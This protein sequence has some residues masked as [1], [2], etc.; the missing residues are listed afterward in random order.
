MRFGFVSVSSPLACLGIIVL[1]ICSFKL[2]YG[3][4]YELIS[5]WGSFGL[6]NGLFDQP[7]QVGVSSSDDTFYVID[8][9]N[10]RIQKFATDGPFIS[11]WGIGGPQ[12]GQ[13]NLPQGIAVDPSGMI[14][15]VADT[16]NNRIQ[17]FDSNGNFV[18][19]WGKIGSADGQLKRPSSITVDG[20]TKEVFVVDSLNNRIQK[21]DSNGNFVTKW[22]TTGSGNGQFRNPFGIAIDS[23]NK[24]Y[25]SDRKNNNIQLF[26]TIQNIIQ[27]YVPSPPATLQSPVINTGRAVNASFSD[28][29][30]AVTLTDDGGS[31]NFLSLRAILVN[32]ELK[33][34]DNEGDFEFDNFDL[35]DWN[36]PVTF[37]FTE[38]SS[39]GLVNVKS[40]LI[41]Q[42]KSY[43]SPADILKSAIYWKQIPLNEQV[44]L[45]LQHKGTNFMI[46]EVQFTD[47]VSGIYSG[48]FDVDAFGS[49]SFGQQSLKSDIKEGVDFKVKRAVKFKPDYSDVYWQLVQSL[50]C[51][52][53]EGHGFTVCT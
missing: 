33:D 25:V 5:K 49:K 26:A 27:P 19:K 23:E 29:P 14:V 6:A 11:K 48:A 7:S 47:G 17:K 45:P 31:E 20:I 53:L 12:Q 9:R 34:A 8:T 4:D 28:L 1:I 30:Q 32:G 16:G 42:V 15:Y 46:V 22:G 37:Q 38:E 43:K 51:K 41:G 36:P 3:A 52:E 24:V 18:T 50:S 10:N 35:N 40:V 2:A 39:V 44:V 21:F 13:F